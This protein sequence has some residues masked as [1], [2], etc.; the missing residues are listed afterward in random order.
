MEGTINN[1]HKYILENNQG[2]PNQGAL[3][4]PTRVPQTVVQPGYKE[5]NKPQVEE[6]LL[7]PEIASSE[8]RIPRNKEV[9][10]KM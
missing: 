8:E 1:F 7:Q 5:Q 4:Q 10:K 3:S 2:A 6:L 9:Q